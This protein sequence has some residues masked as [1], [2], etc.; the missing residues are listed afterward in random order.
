MVGD[1]WDAVTK[2]VLDE[3]TLALAYHVFTSR[4]IRPA[5]P[6]PTPMDSI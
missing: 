4:G 5:T 3:N 1:S 6:L 2:R